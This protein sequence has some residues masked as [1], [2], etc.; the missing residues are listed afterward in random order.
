[1]Q[2]GNPMI[3]KGSWRPGLSLELAFQSDRDAYKPV[4]TSLS[5]QGLAL[6]HHHV[7]VQW[8]I[9]R[10]RDWAQEAHGCSE[11]NMDE[12]SARKSRKRKKKI[13]KWMGGSKQIMWEAF[14]K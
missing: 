13:K 8:M 12:E 5:F 10:T 6:S 9:P 1:M 11:S 14:K 2:Q 7:T 3:T 4:N